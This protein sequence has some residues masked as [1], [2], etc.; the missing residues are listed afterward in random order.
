MFNFSLHEYS[1]ICF[2]DLSDSIV[3]PCSNCKQS[4]VSAVAFRLFL[5]KD[6]ILLLYAGIVIFSQFSFCFISD[7]GAA[8]DGY[9]V[10]IEMT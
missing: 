3:S 2:A 10:S 5:T 4:L 6:H 9:P 7:S 1:S 8:H